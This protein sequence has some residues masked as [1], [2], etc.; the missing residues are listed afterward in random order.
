MYIG[1]ALLRIG[2]VAKLSG[3]SARTIDYYTRCNLL[4]VERSASNYR[5]YPEDVLQTLETIKLLKHQRMSISEIRSVLISEGDAEV[6]EL[7]HE[8]QGEIESLQKKI[9]TLESKL[10]DLPNEDKKKI[11]HKLE[12]KLLDV[13]ELMALM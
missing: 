6:V 7:L 2:Q 13:M 9:I 10:K 4:P 11:Y 1:K 3:L 8:V 5:L 12:P